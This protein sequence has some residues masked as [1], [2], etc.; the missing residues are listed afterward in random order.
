MKFNFE[1]NN[2]KNQVPCPFSKGIEKKL[3]YG[4][5]TKVWPSYMIPI[6]KVFFNNQ[7]GRIATFVSK[8]N[9]TNEKKLDEIEDVNEY[10]G[11]IA[12]YIKD[13]ADIINFKKTK[14]D[15]RNKG[16]IEVGVVADDGRILDGNRRFTCLRELFEETHDPKYEYFCAV[17]LPAEGF[18]ETDIKIM[19][20]SLQ[21]G[22]DPIQVYNPIDKL[23][24][25]YKNAIE[26]NVYNI[27]LW[28]KITKGKKS[29]YK[30]LESEAYVMTDFL[31]YINKPTS[32]YIAKDLKLDGPFVE[33]ANFR[34]KFPE[35]YEDNKSFFFETLYVPTN[36]GDTTRIVRDLIKQAKKPEGLSQVTDKWSDSFG[37]KIHE[38]IDKG[39]DKFEA[40][41]LL[42]NNSTIEDVQNFLDAETYKADIN[43]TRQSALN[44]AKGAC[45]L[46]SQI[47]IDIANS[48][49]ETSKQE[50]NDY[51]DK[52]IELVNEKKIK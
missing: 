7:N 43:E 40:T 22:S 39:N 44:N 12:Q 33:L 42:E 52:I 13:S 38:S 41:D 35:L 37:D 29:D 2:L 28:C 45:D 21:D 46:V 32:Y 50:Y 27:D 26:S 9:E 4:G 8:Y 11:I 34:L 1:L 3:T 24:D 48:M 20:L 30:K 25:F 36:K 23:V 5:S 47:D 17:I 6:E 16:Q 15:I 10:N 51:L 49:D 31:K 18:R 19:E 14:D